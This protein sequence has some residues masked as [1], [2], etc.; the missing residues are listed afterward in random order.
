MSD[1]QYDILIIGAT[2]Y[3]GRLLVEYIGIHQV[4]PT[5]RLA[6]G[7]RTLSKVQDLANRGQNLQA[8]QVDITHEESV[9]NAVAKTRVIINL[10]GPYW[11]HG[12]NVVRA[13]ARHGVHYVDLSGEPYW[14]A[15]MIEQYDYLAYRNKACIIP[16]SGY[17]SIPSDIAAFLSIQTLEKKLSESGVSIPFD[18][19]SAGAH[20]LKGFG[21]SGGTIATMFSALEEVP[22]SE[23]AKG[24]GW[25]LSPGK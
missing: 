24:T 15:K 22:Q 20:K 17:D 4:A 19:K 1:K 23:Q 25:G 21:P 5:L 7:G 16:G 11:A 12:S 3:T 13:C 18:I 8:V 9:D 6:L 10:A 2:G 14:V